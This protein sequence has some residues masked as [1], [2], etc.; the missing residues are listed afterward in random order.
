MC[1]GMAI[2]LSLHRSS[3]DQARA[4]SSRLFAEEVDNCKGK[5][6]FT[7]PLEKERTWLAI[8]VASVGYTLIEC[9]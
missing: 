4:M 5:D 8:F 7:R 2:D 6:T 1:V 3:K 9:L